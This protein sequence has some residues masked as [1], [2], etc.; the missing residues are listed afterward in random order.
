MRLLLG[1]LAYG[2]VSS[3]VVHAESDH[4]L[5]PAISPYP[6]VELQQFHGCVVDGDARPRTENVVE[7]INAWFK[8]FKRPIFSESYLATRKRPEAIEPDLYARVRSTELLARRLVDAQTERALVA[9]VDA[10][11]KSRGPRLGCTEV[12]SAL[13]MR[14]VEQRD[15][16]WSWANRVDRRLYI[17]DHLYRARNTLDRLEYSRDLVE[18]TRRNLEEFKD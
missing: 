1:L 4:L 7:Q 17:L 3:S 6:A 2:L 16:A 13:T 8:E 15:K 10:A 11:I 14:I 5:S 12:R 18:G 9:L